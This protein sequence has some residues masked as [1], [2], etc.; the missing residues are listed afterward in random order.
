MTAVTVDLTTVVTTTALIGA[1][2]VA[3]SVRQ[4]RTQTRVEERVNWLCARYAEDHDTAVPWEEP[5]ADGGFPVEEEPDGDALAPHHFY[6]G[7]AAAVFGFASVWPYYPV[8]GASMALI[9]V[10]VALD[11]LVSHA[12]G[13]P[14]PLD[15][16]WKRA[17]LP[18]VRRVE[19]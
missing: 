4:A 1:G 14:T 11:D 15:Q 19:R 17:I 9:G 13:W 10:A 8:T 3:W 16:L 5:I 18:I 6:V 12:F 7:V 2:A